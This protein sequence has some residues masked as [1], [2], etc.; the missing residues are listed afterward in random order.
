MDIDIENAMAVESRISD[1]DVA[2]EVAAHATSR[3]RAEMAIAVQGQ[4]NVMN[5]TAV[6]LLM[7]D[8]SG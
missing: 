5:Q 7:Q 1:T 4:A 2:M 6:Q 8:K 3:I